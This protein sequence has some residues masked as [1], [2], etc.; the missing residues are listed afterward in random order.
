[1]SFA[2]SESGPFV[3]DSSIA[4]AKCKS[5]I[6]SVSFVITFLNFY[7]GDYFE[8]RELLFPAL[9]WYNTVNG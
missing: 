7:E 6:F 5:R 4:A 9:K 8:K 2:T 1:M 3:A